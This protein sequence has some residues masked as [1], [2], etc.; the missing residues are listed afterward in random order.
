MR[1]FC[2]S[3]LVLIFAVSV[4]VAQNS[5]ADRRAEYNRLLKQR[6]ELLSWGSQHPMAP[7]I[8]EMVKEREAGKIRE[9]LYGEFYAFRQQDIS[10]FK[11]QLR[12]EISKSR[13]VPFVTF[14]TLPIENLRKIATNKKLLIELL[15]TFPDNAIYLTDSFLTKL[16]REDE[17]ME[18]MM[19]SYLMYLKTYNADPSCGDFSEGQKKQISTFLDKGNMLGVYESLCS[20]TL[21]CSVKKRKN[22]AQSYVKHSLAHAFL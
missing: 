5:G 3:V 16:F 19:V 18:N 13:N 1:K 15:R 2:F 21:Q 20:F 10:A 4:G 17:A 22:L 14:N 12:E 6:Q 8:V 9:R 11:R 7:K